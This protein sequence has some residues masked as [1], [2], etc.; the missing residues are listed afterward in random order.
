M[1]DQGDHMRVLVSPASKHGGTV[2]IGRHIAL[3][4]RQRG[5]DV[6]VTQ[7]ED[8]RM[9]EP[10]SGF[11]LGSG[12]YMGKWLARAADFVDEHA[13]SI[14]NQ[15]TW[16][17]SSGPLGEARPAEPIEPEVRDRLLAT[18]GAI[19]HRLFG[20]RLELGL[21]GRTDRFIAKWVNAEE[22]DYRDWNEVED[23]AHSIADHFVPRT[24]KVQV[25]S[26]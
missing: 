8:V 20:G 11:I 21:L 1:F 23:W 15:P 12:L 6:D 22:G 24:E 4:L 13:G 17:F 10:Y 9:F 25:S 18:T 5:I 16:L 26:T 3:I 14:R 19:E 2:E 7:P